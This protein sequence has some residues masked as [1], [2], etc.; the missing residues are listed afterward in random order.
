M[1]QFTESQIDGMTVEFIERNY[2][3]Y[4]WYTT[5]VQGLGQGEEI[6]LEIP[7]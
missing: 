1:E 2:G 6:L 7:C 3:G 4:L 5:L